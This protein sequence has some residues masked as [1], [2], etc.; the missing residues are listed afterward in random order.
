MIL[1]IKLL[2]DTAQIPAYAKHGD[3]GFDLH[4]DN[5]DLICDAGFEEPRARTM[6]LEELLK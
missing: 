4:A 1:Q 5:A 6:A 2:S 3:S